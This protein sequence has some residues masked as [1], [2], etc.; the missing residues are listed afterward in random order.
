VWA[1]IQGYIIKGKLTKEQ[2]AHLK[3][4]L[5][6]TITRQEAEAILNKRI[7]D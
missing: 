6:N 5:I 4:T 7:I 3:A 1:V 2:D